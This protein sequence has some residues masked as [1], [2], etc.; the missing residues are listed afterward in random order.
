[1]KNKS[2]LLALATAVVL[3]ACGNKEAKTTEDAKT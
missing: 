3:G 2:L 1:M